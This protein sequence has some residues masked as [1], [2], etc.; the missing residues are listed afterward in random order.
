[1]SCCFGL[2]RRLLH[3]SRHPAIILEPSFLDR[4]ATGHLRLQCTCTRVSHIVLR[5][6]VIEL[7]AFS[8]LEITIWFIPSLIENAV[9]VALVGLLLGPMYPICMNITGTLVPTWSVGPLSK[10]PRPTTDL[11]HSRLLTGAIGWISGFG[12]TVRAA[13]PSFTGALSQKVWLRQPEPILWSSPCIFDSTASKF[14]NRCKSLA[15]LLFSY[16]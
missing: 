2:K 16:V 10:I 1:V 12:Q 13:F 7:I 8:S 4:R 5:C 9:A 11:R 3:A 15:R 14:L 6:F